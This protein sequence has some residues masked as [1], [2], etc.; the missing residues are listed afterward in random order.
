M[1]FFSLFFFLA[2]LIPSKLAEEEE[3][4]GG[5][6]HNSEFASECRDGVCFQP[7][8]CRLSYIIV[9]ARLGSAIINNDG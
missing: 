1:F 8:V 6:S 7:A 2:G 5:N 9:A 4:G 3:G